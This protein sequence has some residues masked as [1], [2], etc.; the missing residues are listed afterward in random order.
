M[1]DDRPPRLPD[2]LT[3]EWTEWITVLLIVL[4]L[5]LLAVAAGHP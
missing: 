2:W 5:L 1:P 3:H 4:I